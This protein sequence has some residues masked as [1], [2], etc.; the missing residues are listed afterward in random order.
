MRS[1]ARQTTTPTWLTRHQTGPVASQPMTPVRAADRKIGLAAVSDLCD[2]FAE[3]L[4]YYRSAEFDETSCRQRFID[5]F[6]AA[7]GWDVADEE[8]RGPFADVI[9][10]Y[11]LRA[12]GNPA[13]Q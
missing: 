2:Q 10:E 12:P 3:A 4:D 5:P 7:L 6:F 11:S 13:G 9:L 1:R 8:K